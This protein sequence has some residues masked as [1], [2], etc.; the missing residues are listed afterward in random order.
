MKVFDENNDKYDETP[1]HLNNNLKEQ[2]VFEIYNK[3]TNILY[4]LSFVKEGRK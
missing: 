2:N 3:Y 1:I 4:A